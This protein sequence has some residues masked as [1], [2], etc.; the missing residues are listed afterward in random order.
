MHFAD[1][2]AEDGEFCEELSVLELW[3]FGGDVGEQLAIESYVEFEELG[4]EDA[5]A[6]WL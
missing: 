6:G 5:F 2:V 1:E 3:N 4:S